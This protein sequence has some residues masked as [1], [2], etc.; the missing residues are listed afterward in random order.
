MLITLSVRD[1]LVAIKVYVNNRLPI[2]PDDGNK[3]DVERLQRALP[4]SIIDGNDCE[5]LVTSKENISWCRL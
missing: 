5:E 1:I 2:G 3:T 4:M